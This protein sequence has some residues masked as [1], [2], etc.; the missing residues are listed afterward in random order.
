M[1]QKQ[2]RQNMKFTYAELDGMQDTLSKILNADLAIATSLKLRGFYKSIEQDLQIIQDEKNKSI[3]KNGKEDG[4]G[5]IIVDPKQNLQGFNQYV[6]DLNEI[7]KGERNVEFEPLPYSS[8]GE[9]KLS[10]V[11]LIKVE[12][13]FKE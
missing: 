9:I 3:K 4:Q 13:L 2:N 7:Y 6:A 5:N 11:D 8:L 12:K 1:Y 10:A